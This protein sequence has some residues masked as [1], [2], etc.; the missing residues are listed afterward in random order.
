MAYA[1]ALLWLARLVIHGDLTFC[2]N[3]A[4]LSQN[5]GQFGVRASVVRG[6]PK[7]ESAAGGHLAAQLS[8]NF[9]PRDGTQAVRVG[10]RIHIHGFDLRALAAQALYPATDPLRKGWGWFVAL[11]CNDYPIVSPQRSARGPGG[12][13]GS[14]FEDCQACAS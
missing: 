6:G 13:G 12:C 11:L 8:D 4:E 9:A 7:R 10:A 14:R 2:Q 1:G 3:G 5:G